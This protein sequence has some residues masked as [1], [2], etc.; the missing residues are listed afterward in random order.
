MATKNIDI[1]DT[2]SNIYSNHGTV[3]TVVSGTDSTK[4]AALSSF[5]S[6]TF[7]S[8][9]RAQSGSG[10]PVNYNITDFSTP[11]GSPQS[12]RGDLR[13]RRPHR[14]LLFPRGVY[15]R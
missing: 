13:G 2:N 3:T 4:K 9:V 12:Q 11:S 14:G 8:L 1:N 10:S 5:A 7:S 15:G 6:A